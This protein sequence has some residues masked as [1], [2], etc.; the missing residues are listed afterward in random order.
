MRFQRH[1]KLRILT[2]S[3]IIGIYEAEIRRFYRY[4]LRISP[5]PEKGRKLRQIKRRILSS[6]CD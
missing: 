6:Q 5:T 4:V 1:F 3:P 2:D